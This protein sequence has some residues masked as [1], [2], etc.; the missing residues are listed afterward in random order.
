[1]STTPRTDAVRLPINS[2]PLPH[3][4][5][6]ASF[7]RQL[8]TELGEANAALEKAREQSETDSFVV[9]IAHAELLK[10]REDSARLDSGTI[11]LSVCGQRVHFTAQD[12]RAAIDAARKEAEG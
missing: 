12:L 6:Y 9:G 4:V 7:A 11:L 3:D 5:V 1:M 2:H 10:A 8:E